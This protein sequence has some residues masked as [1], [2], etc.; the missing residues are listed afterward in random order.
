[1]PIYSYICKKCKEKFDLLEGVTREKV[2]KVC[3]GCGSKSIEKT[4]STF[5]V[6]KGS[7]S[8]PAMPGGNCSSCSSSGAC[9]YQ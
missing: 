3:P 9:P 2:K 5:G 1:M 4:F 6:G 7:S 8:S